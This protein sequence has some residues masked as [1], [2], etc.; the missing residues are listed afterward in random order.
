MLFG[1]ENHKK[2]DIFISPF[3]HGLGSTPLSQMIL[4]KIIVGILVGS[5]AAVF[6][7]PEPA[8]PFHRL[9]TYIFGSLGLYLIREFLYSRP[10]VQLSV[11]NTAQ[12]ILAYGIQ[13]SIIKR[14]LLEAIKFFSLEKYLEQYPSFTNNAF[15]LFNYLGTF[16]TVYGI[17]MVTWSKIFTNLLP[18]QALS[19][20][21]HILS[22]GM[23]VVMICLPSGHAIAQLLICGNIGREP[24]ELKKINL[25]L[26]IS[27][28]QHCY[29]PFYS[30]LDVVAA[31]SFFVYMVVKAYLW[32]K[33]PDRT[34]FCKRRGNR[35][36]KSHFL[37]CFKRVS[38]LPEQSTAENKA[39][40]PVPN[41]VPLQQQTQNKVGPGC[42][43]MLTNVE[44]HA[45]VCYNNKK[46]LT[47]LDVKRLSNQSKDE[48]WRPDTAGSS[49]GVEKVKQDEEELDSGNVKLHLPQTIRI[50]TQPCHRGSKKRSLD[51]PDFDQGKRSTKAVKRALQYCNVYKVFSVVGAMIFF[52]HIIFDMM[53]EA[54]MTS[55]YYLGSITTGLLPWMPILFSPAILER[56][57]RQM[58][59]YFNRY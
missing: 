3:H 46:E 58:R 18:N 6:C 7:L 57:E 24:K 1:K 42:S 51:I 53:S 49:S 30:V 16:P 41:I 9:I 50:D 19:A 32:M 31:L 29:V 26:G 2:L 12:L 52:V 17:L 27:I 45:T 25:L 20:N 23:I 33:S 10:A 28:D 43:S 48:T 15:G 59:L 39:P 47:K 44:T 14:T 38:A 40:S 5:E 21:H 54:A 34:M 56:L 8:Q 13:G 4:P 36:R 11:V 22:V 55:G 37:V 35:I